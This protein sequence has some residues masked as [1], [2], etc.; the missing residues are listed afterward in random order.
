MVE[1]EHAS[2]LDEYH[3]VVQR[4]ECVA[5]HEFVGGGEKR[6]LGYGEDVVLCADVRSDA[7][8]FV[9]TAFLTEGIDFCIEVGIAHAALED[10]A[11]DKGLGTLGVER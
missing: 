5:M 6:L 7:N 1:A 8:Q 9:D 2:S 10:V 11:E 3:L 4:L